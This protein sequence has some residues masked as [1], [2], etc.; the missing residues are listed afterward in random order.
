MA[1]N[2]KHGEM[3]IRGHEKTYDGFLKWSVR[4]GVAAL[5]V[6]VFLALSGA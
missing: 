5:I 2:Y 4:V 1:E 6:V 3:D